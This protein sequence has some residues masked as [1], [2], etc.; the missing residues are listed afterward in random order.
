MA[1][2]GYYTDAAAVKTKTKLNALLDNAP[3]SFHGGVFRFKRGEY[4]F[5]CTRNHNF[6][7][8]D[9]KGTLVVENTVSNEI[10]APA[11]RKE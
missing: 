4:N 11:V 2:A 7:N 8:R 5:M 9:Q 10:V 3:A 6:S 1:S